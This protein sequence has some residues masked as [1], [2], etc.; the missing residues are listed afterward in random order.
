MIKLEAIIFGRGPRHKYTDE[1]PEWSDLRKRRMG[2]TC[3]THWQRWRDRERQGKGRQVDGLINHSPV[4][5]SEG[6]EKKIGWRRRDERRGEERSVSSLT[7]N[8]RLGFTEKERKKTKQCSPCG[9]GMEL[10]LINWHTVI[11]LLKNNLVILTFNYEYFGYN[12][13]TI[14]TTKIVQFLLSPVPLQAPQFQQALYNFFHTERNTV[15][16]LGEIIS[17]CKSVCFWSIQHTLTTPR[18]YQ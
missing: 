7:W 3:L 13:Y 15:D 9:L 2:G 6:S 12:H 11:K 17:I 16:N 14:I 10:Y 5:R 4:T 8:L 18:W 1:S